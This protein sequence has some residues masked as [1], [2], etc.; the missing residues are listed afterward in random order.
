VALNV[1]HTPG[2]HALRSLPPARSGPRRRGPAATSP[3]M[4]ARLSALLLCL[5]LVLGVAGCG[6]NVQT[7]KP[8]TPAEGVNLDAGAIKIRNLMILSR[9]AGSGFLAASMVS[10]ERDALTGVSGTAIKSD[11]STGG[12]ITSTLPSP[13]AL[14]NGQLVIL[15]QRPLIT[16]TGT[17]LA[18]GLTAKLTLQFSTAGEVNLV[19]PVVNADQI[20]YATI[21]P[22]PSA[23]PSG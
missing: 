17:D 5:G 23:T 15:T 18:P 4:A 10:S 13:V 9:E 8:Y 6:M 1:R 14:G 2:Q 3:S 11:G 12:A 16:V 21:S 19:V 22:S 20:D 7:N